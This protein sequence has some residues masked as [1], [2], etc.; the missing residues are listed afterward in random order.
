MDYSRQMSKLTVEILLQDGRV[1]SSS[2]EFHSNKTKERLEG[3]G[4]A[5]QELFESLKKFAT[6]KA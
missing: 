1:S 4:F 2:V 3:Y 5:D 6:E